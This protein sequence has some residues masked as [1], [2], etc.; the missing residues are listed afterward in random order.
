MEAS[1]DGT[2]QEGVWLE[3]VALDKGQAG[4]VLFIVP[5][6]SQ[7]QGLLSICVWSFWLWAHFLL[8]LGIL[9]TQI[10]DASLQRASVVIYAGCQGLL[11]L[12]AHAASFAYPWAMPTVCFSSPP[13]QARP[14]KHLV[15]FTFPTFGFPFCVCLMLGFKYTVNCLSSFPVKTEQYPSIFWS[16]LQLKI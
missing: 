12:W 6:G 1:L 11:L 4:P 16:C 2:R 7:S 5:D 9:R 3:M 8:M 10:G 13:C 15:G 14:F